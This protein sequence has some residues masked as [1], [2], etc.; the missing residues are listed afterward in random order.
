MWIHILASKRTIT[1]QSSEALDFTLYSKF[2]EFRNYV[3]P[4]QLVRNEHIF[5][6][7][8]LEDYGMLQS[9]NERLVI[10]LFPESVFIIFNNSNSSRKCVVL[11]LKEKIHA[12][13]LE[14]IQ[15]KDIEKNLC[16]EINKY[17]LIVKDN[18]VLGCLGG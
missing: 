17:L 7:I 2:Y 6:H 18:K 14:K 16:I 1:L 3:R 12:K 15:S 9:F 11:E 13:D 4:H 5:S 10:N 8:R